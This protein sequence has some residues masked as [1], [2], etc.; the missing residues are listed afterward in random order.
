M[1]RAESASVVTH[2]TDFLNDPARHRGR[3][4]HGRETLAG[5][6]H[7]FRFAQGKF[8]PGILHD[9]PTHRREE[10]QRAAAAFV[11]QVCFWDGATHYQVLCVDPA[12]SQEAIKEQYH[13]L[14]AL[15]HPDRSASSGDVYPPS[16]AQRANS[17]YAVLSDPGERSRYDAGL[18]M[19]TKAQAVFA[20]P[21]SSSRARGAMPRSMRRK[22]RLAKA[23]VVAASVLATLLLLDAWYGETPREYSL[24]QGL[25]RLVRKPEL[26][27][28]LAAEAPQQSHAATILP[29]E[30][31]V[32]DHPVTATKRPHREAPMRAIEDEIA[33]PPPPAQGIPPVIAARP[34]IAAP[35]ALLVSQSDA[36]PAKEEAVLTSQA[37]ETLVVRL[38]DY[39]EAGETDRLMGLVAADAGYRK[40]ALIRQA[41]ADFFRATRERRLR[42]ETLQWDKAAG[43]AHARGEA[44]LVAR[45]VDDAPALE[46][47][48]EVDVDIVL[49][50]G[51]AKISR[52]SLYPHG[53]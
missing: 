19:A 48:V 22:V 41:Y 49:R 44:T 50:D 40:N 12:A 30:P 17:A 43:A 16:W 18:A 28:Y 27:R 37:I 10:L 46:R 20:A 34:F 6:H 39:Y 8:P 32:K 14:M 3:Y 13:L 29:P 42:V 53:P 2:L 15:I 5:G 11:R 52:L 9:M 33:E 1:P 4:T 35:P 24:F 21:R 36:P 23:A 51:E 31:A 7:V 45:Y 38:V 47:K 25:G 26:P